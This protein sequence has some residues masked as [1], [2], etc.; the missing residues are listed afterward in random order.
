[1]VMVLVVLVMVAA[2]AQAD[3]ERDPMLSAGMAASGNTMMPRQHMRKLRRA[4]AGV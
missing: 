2:H 3:P 4:R 1:M